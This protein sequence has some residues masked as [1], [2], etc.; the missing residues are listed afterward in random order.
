VRQVQD[1]DWEFRQVWPSVCMRK[2]GLQLDGFPLN[3]LH[4]HHHKNPPRKIQVSFQSD[5]G[6]LL[7]AQ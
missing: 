7:V 6:T 3:S 1:S 5:G 4:D 2:T